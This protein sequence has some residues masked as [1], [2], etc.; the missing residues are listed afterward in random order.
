M[1][2]LPAASVN[3]TFAS[4]VLSLSAINPLPGTTALHVPATL[5]IIA[6]YVTPLTTTVTTVFTASAGIFFKLPVIVILP[7]ASVP[8]ITLSEVIGSTEKVTPFVFG[9]VVSEGVEESLL[10]FDAAAIIPPATKGIAA[11]NHGFKPAS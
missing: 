11:N 4:I 3:V 5:S 10:L 1:L 8:L 9:G 6:V 7:A 2:L